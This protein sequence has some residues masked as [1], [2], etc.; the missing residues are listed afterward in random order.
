M[1]TLKKKLEKD[2]LLSESKIILLH[3]KLLFNLF[4]NT[5]FLVK[6]KKTSSNIVNILNFFIKKSLKIQYF[7]KK[8][9][10]S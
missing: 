1:G 6:K 8:E 2:M 5:L 10:L 4:N 9:A 7:L 3:K